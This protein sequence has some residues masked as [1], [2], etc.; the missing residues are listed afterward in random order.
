LISRQRYWGAPIP[1]VYC[2]DCG[3]VPVPEEDLPVLLPEDVEF[4]PSGESPLNYVRSFFETNCPNC[5]KEARRE[6][7]TMDT[8]ICSSWYYLRYTDPH[9]EK[10][11]FSK[12]ANAYWGPV[13]QY[14]GGIEHAI[15]HLLYSRFFLKVLRDAGLVDYDEPFSNLLTQG[16][17]LKDG[18]KM[19]KSVGNVVSPE[20]ILA[21]YGADTARLFILFAA[22]PE[23]ELEWSDQ[24]VDGS[25]R[26]L[27]RVW[28]I[29]Y[30]FEKELA[31]QVTSYDTSKLDDADKDLRRALHATIKKVSED[32]EQRF[33]F[34]T[35]ISSMMEL[36]N[37]MYAYKDAKKEP[38]AG[39][40]YE[41]VRNLLLLLA[42]FVPHITEELWHGVI[43]DQTS[44]HAQKWPVYDAAAI[45][46][47]NV[48]IV[49]QING[50]N[51]DRLTVP[52]AATKAD[53]EK[54]ALADEKIKKLI[55]T[56]KILKVI[57]VPGRLVNIVA[58]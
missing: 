21:K 45:K 39:L 50:K 40:I 44:V 32:V 3:M 37:A 35:A 34:N 15:L 2:N 19:S 52:A 8:F 30:H 22:P 48:E 24:G 49:L 27:N 26:F 23:R 54:L 55:G 9:N 57:C 42:P 38:N 29:V 28:R 31:Q 41:T 5:G 33:N 25:F 11:P 47:D 43:D 53:L 18:G 13:D 56:A 16:M 58:R 10:A 51:R 17:V 4:K 1:I 6:T 7:D 12:E 46:V 14:I 20:E 36:V